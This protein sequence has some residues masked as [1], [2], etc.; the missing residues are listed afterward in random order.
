LD[1]SGAIA[2][3]GTTSVH[4]TLA[5]R[6]ATFLA[7]EDLLG[8]GGCED[9]P[10]RSGDQTAE[11]IA[12][13]IYTSGSTGEPKGVVVQH[14]PVANLFT[15]VQAEFAVGPC[16]RL[17][18]TTSLSFDLSVY[19]IF[20]ILWSGG[21]IHIA[22]EEDIAEPERL[23][24][25]VVD[26][27][28][29][30]W[31]SAPPALGRLI[32]YFTRRAPSSGLRL[33][34]L[35]GDWVPLDLPD[36]VRRAFPGCDVVALG[37]A[38]EA[39]VW[40]NWHRVGD[41]PPHWA[42]IPYG[43]PIANARYYVLDARD[44]AAPFDVEGDLCIGGECLATGYL[45][46]DELTR[47]RFVDDP[48]VLGAKMYR[49]G[50]RAR[51]WRDGTIEFRGR[52]DDQVKIRGY[53][54]ELGEV[55]AALARC[56]GVRD[57]LVVADRGAGGEARLVGYYLADDE[58]PDPSV[59]RAGLRMTLPEQMVPAC[60]VPL[61]RWPL[62][63]NGK[64]DRAALPPPGN[65]DRTGIPTWE[66]PNGVVETELAALW[67]Q[68]LAVGQVGRW[69]NF[70]ELGGHSLLAVQLALGIGER[71]GVD[72]PIITFAG[73]PVLA[74]MAAAI[75][76]AV[77]KEIGDEDEKAFINRLEM[78]SEQELIDMIIDTPK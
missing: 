45:G 11:N 52:V 8:S 44:A 17:L 76:M 21:S 31:D 43:R 20:G 9:D 12:Y 5:D 23:A 55:K 66:A 3:V 63:A 42:S 33:V 56:P 27:G 15:W 1:D 50:D 37:G 49:T 28:I 7:V 36:A 71:F 6:S 22:T 70:F 41:I 60:L 16:D 29:T 75:E 65:R 46:R 48:F 72:L 58:T 47:E 62:T 77:L 4:A 78:A 39:V 74:D 25:L 34:F 61:D 18:F 24:A 30:F 67:K 14:R 54:I 59:L 51:V 10:V 32:P 64:L 19:D 2:V 38:T 26:G 73:A 40:S 57:A 35:S 53:R 68:L 69:D 13:V